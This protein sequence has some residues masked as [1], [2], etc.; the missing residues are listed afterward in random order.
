MATNLVYKIIGGRWLFT[1]YG[2]YDATQ[3]DAAEILRVMRTLDLKQIRMVTYTMGGTLS[4]QHRKEVNAVVGNN[5][6]PL[7]VL[8][9]NPFTRGVIT[10]LSWFNPAVKAF[11]PENELD[12]F[13]YVGIPEDLYPQCSEELHRL[14]AEIESRQQRRQ[15]R[16]TST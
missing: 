10:A 16:P 1:A 7:A 13:S 8:V 12:A 11:A 9:E 2:K 3:E 5:T 6:T 14:I 15:T 4:P